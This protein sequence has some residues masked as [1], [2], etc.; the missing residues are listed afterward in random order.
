[1][2]VSRVDEQHIEL[3]ERLL[4]LHIAEETGA[5]FLEVRRIF[6]A[7]MNEFVSTES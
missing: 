3:A 5:D 2:T 6:L 7:R 4:D 1:M